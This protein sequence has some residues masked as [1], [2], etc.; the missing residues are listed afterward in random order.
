MRRREFITLA[1]GA[2]A[3]PLG[4]L[5]QQSD[6]VRRIGVIVNEAADDAEAQTGIAAFKQNLQQLGWSEGRNLQIEFR[7]AA[8]NLERMQAFAKELVALQ[9]DVILTRST[10]VT[11]PS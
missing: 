7:G 2:A 11:L 4:A 6:E 8:D 5:A 3:W 1:G 10:P 9:P